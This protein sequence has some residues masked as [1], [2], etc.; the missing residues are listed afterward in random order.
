MSNAARKQSKSNNILIEALKD[1]GGSRKPRFS[2]PYLQ[3]CISI[4]L[5]A[6][7]QIFL[8]I[9]VDTQFV[10][11]WYTDSNFFSFWIWLGIL[12]IIG[13]LLSWLY[14]LKSVPLIIAYNLAAANHILV[15]L[16]SWLFLGEAISYRRWIGIFLV[17]I[18]VFFIARPAARAEEK[19]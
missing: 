1:A 16:G 7:S 17:A 11:P 5:T 10:S 13:S 15:A 3:L 8:K 6:A 14:A 18:G 4:I 19:L 2:H 9:G 12:A